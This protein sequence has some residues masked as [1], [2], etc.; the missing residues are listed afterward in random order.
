MIKKLPLSVCLITYNEEKNL[1][2]TLSAI[3]DIAEEIIIIDSFS[4]DRTCEIAREYG[5]KIFREEWTG[6]VDQKNSAIKKCTKEWILMLDADEVVSPQLKVSLINEIQNPCADAYY[7]N[8]KTHYLGKLMNYAWQ[9]DWNLRLANRFAQ[10]VW[11]GGRVHESLQTQ[12][13][14]AKLNGEI[15]HYS[16]N[17]IKHHFEKTIRYA[18][19]SAQSYYE[20]GKRASIVN[21]LINPAYAFI[22]LYFL[23]RGMLDGVRGFIAAISSAFGTFMK[24]AFLW[25]I[26]HK[27]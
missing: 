4:K 6:F 19:I 15:I 25:E 11:K 12:G 8:R 16:Y 23:R 21:I 14:T 24:Y 22:R 18:E 1:S 27:K 10:P 20:K 26:E 7:I 13:R 17:G 2:R 3:I 5:V 9:P